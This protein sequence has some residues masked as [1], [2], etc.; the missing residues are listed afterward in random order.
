LLA[1]AA[2]EGLMVGGA[3]LPVVGTVERRDDA[4]ALIETA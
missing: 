1:R 4:F 3:H 2:D